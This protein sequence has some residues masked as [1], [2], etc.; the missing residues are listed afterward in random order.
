MRQKLTVN[1][2]RDYLIDQT[3]DALRRDAR[4]IAPHIVIRRRDDEPN[5]DASVGV[6]RPKVLEAF[7]FVQRQLQAEYDIAW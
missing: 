2:I 7:T 1:T 4:F 3:T 6:Q 5:W